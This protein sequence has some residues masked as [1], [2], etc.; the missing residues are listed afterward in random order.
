MNLQELNNKIHQATKEELVSNF[1]SWTSLL[2]TELEADRSKE[3]YFVNHAGRELFRKLHNFELNSLIK[4]QHDNGFRPQKFDLDKASHRNSV[5]NIAVWLDSEHVEM[6]GNKVSKLI[7]RS[8]NGFDLDSATD[9][10]T[11]TNTQNGVPV[12]SIPEGDR[13][14][15]TNNRDFTNTAG[16]YLFYMVAK[17]STAD[18]V[19]DAILSFNGNAPG[20]NFQIDAGEANI[21]HSRLSVTRFEGDAS[22]HNSKKYYPGSVNKDLQGDFYLFGVILNRDQGLA[23]LSLD[24]L[25][26]K[27]RSIPYINSLSTALKMKIF[28]NRGDKEF[29]AGEFGE[30]IMTEDLT[31]RDEIEFYLANKWGITLDT[32]H[33][34]HSSSF[35]TINNVSWTPARISTLTWF[36]SSNAASFDL[37]GQDVIQ[38]NDLS[39]ND[40]HAFQDLKATGGV[41]LTSAYLIF[42]AVVA[43][44]TTK[45]TLTASGNDNN[46]LSGS[47]AESGG[48]NEITFTFGD[49][50]TVQNLIDNTDVNSFVEVLGQGDL[51]STLEAVSEFT[52]I[53]YKRPEKTSQGVEF[54]GSSANKDILEVLNDPY[55]DIQ[56][57]NIFAVY[58]R[59]GT[60]GWGNAVVSF[61]GETDGGAQGWQLR[62]KQDKIKTMAFTTRGGSHTSPGNENGVAV[63]GAEQ[64]GLDI[65][66]SVDSGDLLFD[67]L[68][69]DFH[70]CS[71]FIANDK[72]SINLNGTSVYDYGMA[73]SITYTAPSSTNSPNGINQSAVG[74]RF[75]NAEGH[76]ED[77]VA[78]NG[79]LKGVIKEVIVLNDAT[80]SNVEKIE[81]YLAHKWNLESELPSSHTYKNNPPTF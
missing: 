38:W 74:G 14:L 53:E 50:V 76:S 56:N 37:S 80:A 52:L 29:P 63:E 54:S 12:I 40:N 66:S 11:I 36:D 67:F 30:F 5:S 72:K 6:S 51:S 21:F 68:D 27:T 7:D 81:G 79:L 62:Q 58:K 42:K 47:Q 10:S 33:A 1:E 9:S 65:A 16:N 3:N 22:G 15:H 19:N 46:I 69:G 18:S 4:D 57:P 26:A 45:I 31:M 39:G 73:G 43:G 25:A 70:I 71:A 48:T 44:K 34:F 61:D 35:Q 17:V 2:Q 24:G 20:S 55:K 64:L 75:E 49:Q 77:S 41:G 13:F 59:N 8:G 28:G 32:S 60:K 78:A 23:T